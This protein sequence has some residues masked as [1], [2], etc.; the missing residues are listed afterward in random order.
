[1]ADGFHVP[2]LFVALVATTGFFV[3]RFGKMIEVRWPRL[4]VFASLSLG[5]VS[6]AF[7]WAVASYFADGSQ[8]SCDDVFAGAAP[9]LDHEVLARC[10]ATAGEGEISAGTV[11]RRHPSLHPF[12]VRKHSLSP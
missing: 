7:S 5:V 6:V 2:V 1:L 9:E 3:W 12:A 11:L 8:P 4:G 10:V